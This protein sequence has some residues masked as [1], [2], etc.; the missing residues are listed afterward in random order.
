MSVS[1]KSE[2]L[3]AQQRNDVMGQTRRSAAQRTARFT[4]A[5]GPVVERTRSLEQTSAA[6]LL[7]LLLG[8]PH[9]PL[10]E[11]QTIY[12]S[13]SGLGQPTS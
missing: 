2:L 9:T 13:R 7:L 4:P 8:L 3:T 10:A 11:V 5:A 12:S 6:P 1:L